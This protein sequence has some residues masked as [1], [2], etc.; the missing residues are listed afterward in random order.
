MAVYPVRKEI[1]TEVSFTPQP[2]HRAMKSVFL[3]A[4]KDLP[5]EDGYSLTR[6]EQLCPDLGVERFW[7]LPGFPQWFTNTNE[8]EQMAD[9]ASFMALQTAMEVMGNPDEKGQ[10]RITAAKLAIEVADK[11]PKGKQTSPLPKAIGN[12]DEEQLKA[13]LRSN[14]SLLDKGTE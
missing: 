1:M 10:A 4:I 7:D 5:P 13:F 2:I 14:M 12:M 8:F 9:V 11:V 3:V 6:I